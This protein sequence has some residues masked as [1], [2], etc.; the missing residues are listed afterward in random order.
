M[1]LAI[2]FHGDM[3]IVS[4]LGIVGSTSFGSAV[5]TNGTTLLDGS[6]VELISAANNVQD[7]WAIELIIWNGGLSATASEQCMDVLVGGATDDV[8]IPALICGHSTAAVPRHYFFPLHIPAGKRIA[9]LLAGVRTTVTSRVGCLLYGG[10][11]PP[12]EVGSRV[13]TY[14]TQINNAR[15]QQITPTASGGAHSVAEMTASTGEDLIAAI[16]GWQPHGGTVLERTYSM[17]IGLGASV[18]ERL[19]TWW[20][21]TSTTEQGFGPWP[22]LPVWRHIPAGTRLT[23]LASNSGTNDASLGDGLIYGVAA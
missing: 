23:F 20:F 14:G 13:I 10:S 3:R 16:P 6:I 8:L 21:Q 1:G 9:C 5:A 19:G 4:N 11:P 12:F 17:G 2:P 7:S 15:G 18:E 22:L